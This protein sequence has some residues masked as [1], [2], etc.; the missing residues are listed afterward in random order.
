MFRR[1]IDQFRFAEGYHRNMGPNPII[2]GH[3]HGPPPR[4]F[5]HHPPPRG[6]P[7]F[8]PPFPMPIP[9]SREA[10]QDI[11]IFVILIIISEHQ[12]GITGYQLQERFKLPRGTLIR[13]LDY[14]DKN[15]IQL[16]N[17]ELLS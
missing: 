11:K 5:P 13:T 9:F 6:F 12:E 1:D 3:P 10:F 7:F 14:L 17:R 15:S 2:E 4:G 8:P 16:Q